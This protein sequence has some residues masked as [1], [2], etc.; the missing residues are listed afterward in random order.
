[1]QTNQ[2]IGKRFKQW[3]LDKGMTQQA[4]ADILDRS[5]NYICHVETRGSSFAQ[6]SLQILINKLDL[7]INWL[8]TGRKK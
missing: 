1:L 3:R 8:L 2:D 6:E 7:D 5:P 4:I